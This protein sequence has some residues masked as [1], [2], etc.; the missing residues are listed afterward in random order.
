MMT[1]VY[2]QDFDFRV[3]CLMQLGLSSAAD[4]FACNNLSI[5]C[6]GRTHRIQLYNCVA[7]SLLLRSS[8]FHASSH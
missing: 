6:I 2:Q 8:L 7:Q 1:C 5:A 3:F 4:Y